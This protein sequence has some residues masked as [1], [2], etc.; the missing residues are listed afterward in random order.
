MFDPRPDD[1]STIPG[2]QANGQATQPAVQRVTPPVYSTSSYTTHRLTPPPPPPMRDISARERTRRR[3]SQ[4][5]LSEWAW[6]VV[7]AALFGVVL[8]ISVGAVVAIRTNQQPQEY[9]PTADVIASLPT[10]VV[11]NSNSSSNGQ[12]I[13]ADSLIMPDGSN[14]RLVPWDGQSRFT[15][16][17]VGLD[18]R[19]GETG[20][21]YRTDTMMLISIDPVS[22]SIG[23]LSIPRDLYVQLPGYS[24]L[25]R[26]N[27]A[28]IYGEL[29]QAGYGPTLMMQTVQ[30][31]LGIRVNDYMAVDFQSFEDI[32]NA[33]GGIDIVT[34]YTINDR[35]YPDMNY[36][37]DP[38]YLPAGSH[39]LEGYDALRFARTRHGDSD[40]N[41]AE[42]QQQTLLAVR[43][44]I[45]NFG[46]LPSLIGQAPALWQSLSANVYT[47]LSFEQLIQLGLYIKDIP[48]ENIKMGVITYDYLIPF[49]TSEGASVLVPNR[50]ALGSLM[51][52]VFGAS[53]TQ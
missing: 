11:A 32:V 36:G 5:G 24:S 17:L 15:M 13:L 35:T 53:Y 45:L 47:G 16:I 39:H 46:Q 49:S 27:S 10:A 34:D 37:Y 38:F 42:R 8:V 30:L 7:A 48:Q 51:L 41:R 50:G 18:R 52:E 25:Q 3:R 31:N 20:L 1:E 28:L 29:E 2:K 9:F 19:P 22:K 26:V 6:V 12:Q 21:A 40:I 33:I 44:K 4:G 14:I 23:V 43:D